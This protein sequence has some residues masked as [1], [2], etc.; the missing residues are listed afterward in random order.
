MV[1]GERGGGRGGRILGGVLVGVG[2]GGGGVLDMAGE[3]FVFFRRFLVGREGGRWNRCRGM[4]CVCSVV[5]RGYFSVAI[6]TV[7]FVCCW[8]C[9][10]EG[11]IGQSVQ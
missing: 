1:A 6:N 8:S 2:V 10:G 7:V 9:G 5:L 3:G 4:D 11:V